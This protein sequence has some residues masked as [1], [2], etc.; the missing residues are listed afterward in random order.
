MAVLMLLRKG[1]NVMEKKFELIKENSNYALID[2]EDATLRIQINDLKIESKDIFEKLLSKS[3]N[4]NSFKFE[5]T[6]SL[7]EKEDKRILQQVQMLFSKIENSL[8]EIDSAED[9]NL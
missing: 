5:I 1:G 7:T 2:K 9:A 4:E 8:N 6:T 3:V